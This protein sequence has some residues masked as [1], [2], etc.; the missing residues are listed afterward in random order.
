MRKRRDIKMNIGNL[1]NGIKRLIASQP[2]AGIKIV[3]VTD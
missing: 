1:R 2:I 3:A